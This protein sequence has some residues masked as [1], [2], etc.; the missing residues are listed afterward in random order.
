MN[1]ISTKELCI[2]EKYAPKRE[3]RGFF[4]QILVVKL[5]NFALR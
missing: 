3:L 5:N 2:W 1:V 4:Y